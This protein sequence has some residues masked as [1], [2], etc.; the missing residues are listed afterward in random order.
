MSFT[1]INCRKK[2]FGF[3]LLLLVLLPSR[4]VWAQIDLTGEWSPR[5]Y[6]DNRDVPVVRKA[7]LQ[8]QPL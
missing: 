5:V 2:A 4:S 6:N 3:L 7:G 1:N 8:Y